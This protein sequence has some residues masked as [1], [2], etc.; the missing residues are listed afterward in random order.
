MKGV[1]E[2]RRIMTILY[3]S[4]AYAFVKTSH[5]VNPVLNLRDLFNRD[6]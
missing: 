1:E 2:Y 5:L 6:C 3:E 4:I